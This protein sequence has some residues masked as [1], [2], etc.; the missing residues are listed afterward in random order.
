VLDVDTTELL[1]RDEQLAGL[2]A[3]LSDVA[4]RRSGLLVLVHGEAGIGKTALVRQFCAQ[5]AGSVGVLWATCD[6]LFTPRP[7][8]PLLDIARVTDGEL[9]K[10]VEA[11]G[12]PYDVARALMDELDRSSPSVVVVEDLHWA[13][14]ATLD[15]LRLC[16][17]RVDSVPALLVGTYRD[18]CLGRSHP[19]RSM[20]GELPSGLS[21]RQELA[22]LSGDAVARL[23]G[24]SPLDPG[25]LYERTGG[26]PFYVTEVLAAGGGRIP[27]TV[28]DAVLARA[29]GLSGAARD[30]LEAV[31]VVPQRTEVWLLEALVQRALDGLDE[32]LESGMLRGEADGV[33]FRHELARLAIEESLTPHRAVVLHRRALAA[34]AEPAIGSP[35]L[36]RLAHHA[37]V[38]GDTDAVLRYAPLAAEHAA[39]VGAHREALHQYERALRFAAGLAAGQRA[40]LLERLADEGF[41]TDMRE[42]GL[43]AL[44]EAL[45]IHRDAGDLLRAGDVLR[46][47]ARTKGDMGRTAEARVDVREATEIL[48]RLPPGIELARTYAEV[49]CL[50]MQADDAEETIAWGQKAIALADRLGGDTDT[51]AH[52]LN[53]IGTVEL[54]RGDMGGKEK[55]ERSLELARSAG[56]L[57]Y[58]AT[59]YIDLCAALSRLGRYPDME[60][61][62]D[63]GIKY[64]EEHGLE[65]WTKWLL[66]DK[67]DIQLAL[68]LWDQ[69]AETASSILDAPASTMAAV[70]TAG[71]TRALV[72]ARRGDPDHRDPLDRAQEIARTVDDLQYLAPVAAAYAECAWLEG[73][74]QEIEAVTQAAFELAQRQNAATFIGQLGLWRWRAGL[75]DEPPAAAGEPYSYQIAGDWARATRYWRERECRYEAALALADS[76]EGKALREALD[77]LQALGARPAAAIVA[78][79]LR[80]LGERGLPRGPRRKTRANPAG[81]TAR[82]LEV[83]RLLVEGLRNAQIAERLVLSE[84]TV[85]HHVSAILRKLDVRS[86]GEATAAAGRL[87]LHQSGG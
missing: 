60:R 58:V 49:S 28:R 15:V 63:E 31:A 54:G 5:M 8:G 50:T 44:D 9:R 12:Q 45:A 52:A 85:D 87:G 73:R 32:C 24:T 3:A 59:G 80:E 6:A 67:A 11:G 75:L 18:D 27:P 4:G 74:P 61:Y 20:L 57:R 69:A 41:L 42:E 56:E 36:A 83:L 33:A 35:D 46:L 66:A 13:D 22:R 25:E 62:A 43:A 78:R 53:T 64:C 79:R 26:N 40:R 77:E 82:E 86:R 34:L 48:E 39:T 1:E 2:V 38:A 81:L 84:K 23:A 7:L 14:E 30:V 65:A 10:R 37:E 72:R 51:L 16:A 70:H 55:L 21:R 76:H 19:L 29:A 71:L 68:G 47:R 17:R